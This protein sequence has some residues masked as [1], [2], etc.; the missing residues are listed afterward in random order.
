[1]NFQPI[2]KIS[3]TVPDDTKTGIVSIQPETEGKR[4]AARVNTAQ[5]VMPLASA[6]SS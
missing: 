1:M 6:D 2:P 3:D 5:T 4:D